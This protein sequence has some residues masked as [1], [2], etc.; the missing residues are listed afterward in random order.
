MKV[1]TFNAASVRARLDG[2]IEW[3]AVNEPDV[4]CIQET[5][6]EDDKF[7]RE[8][9]EA[10]G[11]HL[12]LNGQKSWNGVAIAS[13]YPLQD[14]QAGFGD[15]LMPNDARM[16]TARIG[17][18][19]IVNT[20][21][22]N[23]NKVGSD[24]W[25]YKMQWLERFAR[26]LRERYRPDEHLI[27][28]GDVNIAPKPE[29]VYDSAKVLGG[30]GHHPEEFRRLEEILSFGLTDVFRKFETGGGHFTFWDFVIPRGLDRNLGW[31]IDHIYATETLA[32]RATACWIDKEPRLAPKPS[33]HT[34]VVA[35]FRL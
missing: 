10:L 2:I 5:K 29:D 24:K 34:Y 20:Y 9:F 30:V 27:W 15:D 23:G 32:D 12:A 14:V 25:A 1:A 33:D 17:D 31:R 18:L 7:P 6:V 35:E 8:D 13:R 4:L 3:L 28:L 22:P 26:F 11:Y 19:A 21:V 16:V